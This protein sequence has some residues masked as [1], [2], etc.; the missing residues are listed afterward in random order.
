MNVAHQAVMSGP[1][2]AVWPWTAPGHGD[3]V[4]CVCGLFLLDV[5][6]C[7]TLLPSQQMDALFG[8]V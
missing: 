2:Q 4:V 5:G 7:G 8:E 6:V 3:T 1:R